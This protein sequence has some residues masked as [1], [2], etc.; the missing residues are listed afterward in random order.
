ME[1]DTDHSAQP[2]AATKASTLNL[3]HV[4]KDKPVFSCGKCSEVLVRVQ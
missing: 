2:V 3:A 1:V 4:P